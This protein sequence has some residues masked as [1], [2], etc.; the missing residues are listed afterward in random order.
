MIYNIPE[1][2]A[3]NL[4][5]S[6]GWNI[7]RIEHAMI[8]LQFAIEFAEIAF[9]HIRPKD[10]LLKSRCIRF[11][12]VRARHICP[13]ENRFK[14]CIVLLLLDKRRTG[15]IEIHIW[16][17]TADLTGPGIIRI[18]EVGADDG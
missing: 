12:G 4:G 10:Q 14:E 8:A 6:V 11:W 15:D 17:P 9:E 2:A 5:L 13:P 18:P 3:E 16:I 1:R 7:A